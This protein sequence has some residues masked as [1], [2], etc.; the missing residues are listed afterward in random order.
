MTLVAGCRFASGILLVG[1]TKITHSSER[2]TAESVVEAPFPKVVLLSEDIAVGVAGLDPR[3]HVKNLTSLRG[4]P[5][6]SVLD[7]ATSQ[8]E[9]SFVVA[10]LSGNEIWEIDQGNID[11]VN[12][13]DIATVGDSQSCKVFG[14]NLARW[15]EAGTP[16]HQGVVFSLSHMVVMGGSS[17][18]GGY[19]ISAVGHEGKFRLSGIAQATIYPGESTQQLA[20][21]G[22][23]PSDGLR[24]QDW[25][26]LHGA[27]QTYAASAF[28]LASLQRAVLYTHESPWV[29]VDIAA[30]SRSDLAQTAES[31]YSQAIM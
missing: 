18:V 25:Q 4:E 23:L 26:V 6:E 22:L 27:G 7:Y 16:R 9:A 5:A 14:A 3:A 12:G 30:A 17:A 2:T 28:F 15:D 19:M 24:I 13:S 8:M 29:G 21:K 31:R 20:A 11:V 1:D 10:R